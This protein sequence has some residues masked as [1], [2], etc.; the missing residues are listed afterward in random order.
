MSGEE[1]EFKKVEVKPDEF[2][3][4]IG[5]IAGNLIRDKVGGDAGNILAGL[6]DNVLSGGGGNKGGFG[7]GGGGFGGGGGGGNDLGGLLGNLLGGG[8]NRGNQ[9]G[10]GFGGGGGG[11][12]RCVV[13]CMCD[14]GSRVQ[15]INVVFA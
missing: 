10:G 11:V 8:G 4:L 3:G 15:L 9:G 14:Y 2:N 12:V 7:A 13:L 1:E 5:N 6:A